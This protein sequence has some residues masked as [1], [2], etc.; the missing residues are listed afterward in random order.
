M[1]IKG[2]SGD[3]VLSGTP[4]N[5]RFN[6]AQGGQDT[7]SSGDGND[8]FVMGAALDSGDR[9]DGGTGTDTVILSGDYSAG[10]I[11]DAGTIVNIEAL[12]LGA[13][14]DYNLTLNDGNVAAGARLTVNASA[15]GA[16]NHL[17]FDGSAEHDGHF[18]IYDGAGD[19]RITGGALGDIIRAEGGGHDTVDGGGGNDRIYMPGSFTA[20]DKIDG[21]IGTDTLFL[22]G[23]GSDSIAFTDT[24]M[25][26]VEK[27][28][29][30]TGHDYVLATADAT[31][32][33][34]RTLTVDASAMGAG[35]TL[36]FNGGAESDGAFRFIAGAGA[37]NL[38]GGLRND[39]FDFT[40]GGSDIAMG[41]YG[42]D[43]FFMGGTLDAGDRINGGNGNGNDTVVLDGDY[44]T[45]L[46]LAAAT[47]INVETIAFAAGHDYALVA[48]NGNVAAG[49]TLTVDGSALGASDTLAFDGSA[50]TNGAFVMKGGA[51]ADV[52]TGGGGN[53]SFDLTLG[54]ADTVHGG[55]GADIIHTAATLLASQT[56]DGGAGDDVLSLSGSYSGMTL[57]PSQ[58]TGI[59]EV[60]FGSAG[61]L[62]F[63]PMTGDF[64]GGDG[65]L[66]L[67][68]VSAGA[69]TLD[70]SGATLPALH[71]IGGGGDDSFTFGDNFDSSITVDGGGATFHGN[72][73]SFDG[74][75]TG[76]NA[77]VC[78]A[79]TIMHIDQLT[80]SASHSY[81]ITTALGTYSPSG[82]GIGSM[83]ID[84]SALGTS[85]TLYFDGSKDPDGRYTI[86]GGTGDDTIIAGHNATILAGLGAD[87]IQLSAGGSGTNKASIFYSSAMESTG[88]GFD[89]IE[90]MSL[91]K[92][93]IP[94]FFATGASHIV[95]GTLDTA[96]FDSE[97]AGLVSGS[98]GGSTNVVEVLLADV[99]GHGQT[100]LIV[101][102]MDGDHAYEAGTDLVFSTPGFFVST[103]DFGF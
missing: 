71:L 31:V 16:A 59:N 37:A 3:D 61:N 34:G 36:Y 44:H 30:G 27:L 13:G 93:S 19:D 48:N 2:T 5:D 56:I 85:D 89:T 69:V 12:R 96:N 80:F 43:T 18:V 26:N 29:L 79:G 70:V 82:A 92:F 83:T 52:L 25:V 51:G 41:G 72:A 97:L 95:G 1:T 14:F 88:T 76:A 42:Q 54:G 86:F 45:A 101:V 67:S 68:F 58:L 24:T 62:A 74:D 17:V 64:T 55:G 77:I 11:F 73:L 20:G 75:Y 39:V 57:V 100:N 99:E 87:D 91:G 98:L 33:A 60:D 63:T 7:V 22:N 46:V 38:T 65:D 40:H 90:N 84:A 15:L 8:I 6:L 49:K 66:T 94:G 4:G 81:E 47:L 103:S 102:D 53:D 50:E 21:G 9:L 35:D 23:L 28:V 10:L 32:A 78:D